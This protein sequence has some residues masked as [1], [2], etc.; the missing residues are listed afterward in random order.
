MLHITPLQ[1]P[2]LFLTAVTRH[3]HSCN[4]VSICAISTLIDDQRSLLNLTPRNTRP[5]FFIFFFLLLVSVFK[6]ARLRLGF[7]VYSLYVTSGRANRRTSKLAQVNWSG[8]DPAPGNFWS[9]CFVSHN[10]FIAFCAATSESMMMLIS[11]FGL[12]GGG[13]FSCLLHIQ[14]TPVLTFYCATEL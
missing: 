9:Y 2:P 12:G 5:D 13:L 10:S 7:C 11:F 4:L 14:Y 8:W 3:T 6:K 1:E